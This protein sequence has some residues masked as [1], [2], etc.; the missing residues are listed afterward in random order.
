MIGRLARQWMEDRILIFRPIRPRGYEV[1]EWN[2]WQ[3][4][5]SFIYFLSY[6]CRIFPLDGS[7]GSDGGI[8][9][10]LFVTSLSFRFLVIL[11][12]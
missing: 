7:E 4:T 9:S 6:I 10:N 8:L 2:K 3:M 11:R 5:V 1:D 12:K